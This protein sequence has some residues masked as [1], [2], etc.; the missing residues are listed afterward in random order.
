MLAKS[1]VCVAAQWFADAS[2]NHARP[3]ETTLRR[4]VGGEA[5]A[6]FPRMVCGAA[7][8]GNDAARCYP[9]ILE[10]GKEYV[11]VWQSLFI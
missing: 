2:R 10:G 9:D 11:H 8:V 1:V 7:P 6:R 3:R 5:H 4:D